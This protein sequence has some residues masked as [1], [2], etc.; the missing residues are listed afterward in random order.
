[1]FVFLKL[2]KHS[3]TAVYRYVR[4]N[5]YFALST[6]II[7][8]LGLIFNVEAGLLLDLV[9]LI[10]SIAYLNLFVALSTMS[11][12]ICGAIVRSFIQPLN[13]VERRIERVDRRFTEWY[14]LHVCSG[15]I[16]FMEKVFYKFTSNVVDSYHSTK[17]YGGRMTQGIVKV[18]NGVFFWATLFFGINVLYFMGNVLDQ[19]SIIDSILPPVGL[20]D[21]IEPIIQL[22]KAPVLLTISAIISVFGVESIFIAMAVYEFLMLIFFIIKKRLLQKHP[23]EVPYFTFDENGEGDYASDKARKN[24]DVHEVRFHEN[25]ALSQAFWK[26]TIFGYTHDKVIR[27]LIGDLDYLDGNHWYIDYR[28]AF[29]HNDP[30]KLSFGSNLPD[31]FSI[32]REDFA[33][34]WGKEREETEEEKEDMLRWERWME[35][36][37]ECKTY[38][39][40]IFNSEHKLVIHADSSKISEKSSNFPE[41]VLATIKKRMKICE[42][43]N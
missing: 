21:M 39:V 16:G 11:C 20:F 4:L 32:N 29:R 7:Y 17:D 9:K 23:S 13:V 24:I 36:R 25:V 3:S 22:F 40:K 31:F 33:E 38:D 27:N 43:D 19:L 30:E 34:N 15:K 8:L 14:F 35:I 10:N 41:E 6:S 18:D 2:T 26:Q 12:L 1:M 37:E 28:R 5:C 42:I